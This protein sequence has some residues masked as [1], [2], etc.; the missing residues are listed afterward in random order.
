MLVRT[1]SGVLWTISFLVSGAAIASPAL[2]TR[3]GGESWLDD[4]TENWLWGVTGAAASGTWDWAVDNLNNLINQPTNPS[5][6]PI[7]TPPTDSLDNLDD[8][9]NP[10]IPYTSDEIDVET[11]DSGPPLA[12]DNCKA[13]LQIPGQDSNVS[14]QRPL[15]HAELK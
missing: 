9:T 10:P 14:D 11:T 1:D 12:D 7:K 13:Q 5:S 15:E 6:D 3:Q 2:V 8:K 4:P